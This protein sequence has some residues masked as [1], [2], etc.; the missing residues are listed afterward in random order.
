MRR[1]Y[2]VNGSTAVSEMAIVDTFTKLIFGEETDFSARELSIIQGLRLVECRL[3]M[4]CHRDIGIYLRALGVT[5]MV[6]LVSSVRC[7]MA[8]LPGLS[9]VLDS[10][11]YAGK[12]S[13]PC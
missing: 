7:Q 13:H 2:N 4:D 9:A 5:E 1:D 10:G 12:R 3:D 8:K 6:T 11:S